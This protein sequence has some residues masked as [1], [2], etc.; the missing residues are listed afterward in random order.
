[1][2]WDNPV[3]AGEVL[4][5]PGIQSPNFQMSPLVG[6]AILI[7]GAA[8]F[9]NLTLSGT[10]MGTNYEI[11]SSGAFFYSGTPALG[12]L[13]ASI[14]NANGTDLQGNAYLQGI[15]SYRN[16][17]PGSFYC[18]V[19]NQAFTAYY[20]SNAA[21]GPWAFQAAIRG[22]FTAGVLTFQAST[23]I[24][25]QVPLALDNLSAPATP[26][27][28]AWLYGGSGHENTCTDGNN[29]NTGRLTLATTGTQTISATTPGVAV[30]GLSATVAGQQYRITGRIAYTE[31]QAA[32]TPSFYFTAPAAA[33][34]LVSAFTMTRGSASATPQTAAV[35][36]FGAGNAFSGPVMT[37][38]QKVMYI[39]AVFTAGGSGGFALNAFTSAA[40]DT[41]TLQPG[42]FLDLM[43]VT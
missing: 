41:F 23:N 6:W 17:S 1:M 32:G 36:G 3:V 25:T 31:N 13:I 8:Y 14:A 2:A 19:N 28:A 34:V 27:G 29:Y 40:A 9:A 42:S 4:A 7:S 24:E 11:N 5:I 39:E 12:N 37:G 21:C 30:T 18:C 22:D 43:P 26:T 10:F 38:V 20:F 33:S 15:A 16:P 35:T